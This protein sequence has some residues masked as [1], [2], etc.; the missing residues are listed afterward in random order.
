MG[1]LMGSLPLQCLRVATQT[2]QIWTKF[3]PF[4]VQMM[5][6]IRAER[7]SWLPLAGGNMNRADEYGRYA[8]E[9]I[10]LARETSSESQ[11]LLL[12]RMAQRWREL[13]DRSARRAEG[14]GQ[15]EAS[16]HSRPHAPM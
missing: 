13:A 8:A 4:P 5:E 1:L 9:C 15:D 2:E 16:T 14:S 6:Q 12:L 11:K 7:V 3:P 10:R